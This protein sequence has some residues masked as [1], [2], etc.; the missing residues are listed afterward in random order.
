[1]SETRAGDHDGPPDR[2]AENAPERDAPRQDVPEEGI[3]G[4]PAPEKGAAR[5]TSGV[6]AVPETDVSQTTDAEPTV[7]EQGGLAR[8]R[9]LRR[10][11]VRRA[12]RW[13]VRTLIRTRWWW[14]LPILVLAAWLRWEGLDKPIW[15]DEVQ[16]ILTSE[17]FDLWGRP[18]NLLRPTIVAG[19]IAGWLTWT[20]ELTWVRL[21]YLLAGLISIWAAWRLGRLWGDWLT[22]VALALGLTLWPFK[23]YWDTM[24]RDYAIL[25][26]LAMGSLYCWERRRKDRKLVSAVAALLLTMM[27][28]LSHE[29]GWVLWSLPAYY[30][31]WEAALWVGR[32]TGNLCQWASGK[33]RERRR[34]KAEGNGESPERA[35]TEVPKSG[36]PRPSLFRQALGWMAVLA[37][38]AGFFTATV[39][40]NFGVE[41]SREFAGK[42]RTALI[43][44]DASDVGTGRGRSGRGTRGARAA[45]DNPY[46]FQREARAPNP[47]MGI[48][49][50]VKSLKAAYG[51]YT[52]HGSPAMLLGIQDMP[53]LRPDS[54]NNLYRMLLLG[55]VERN[56]DPFVVGWLNR[57]LLAGLALGSL[58]ALRRSPPLVLSL[59]TMIFLTSLIVRL[60]VHLRLPMPRYFSLAGLAGLVLLAIAAGGV[61]GWLR[62][63]L[64]KFRRTRALAT[65]AIGIAGAVWI[66]R[67][68]TREVARAA[69]FY[70]TDW[71]VL[72][73]AMR[74][75]YPEGVLFVGFGSKLVDFQKRLAAARFRREGSGDGWKNPAHDTVIEAYN[76]DFRREMQVLDRINPF[77]GAVFFRAREWP[78]SIN[79]LQDNHVRLRTLNYRDQWARGVHAE[80]ANKL[81]VTRGRVVLPLL[82]RFMPDRRPGT[83]GER[84]ARIECYF[85]TP[86]RYELWVI[87]GEGAQ[88]TGAKWQGRPAAIETVALEDAETDGVAEL[89]RDMR[90]LAGRWPAEPGHAPLVVTTATQGQR[91]TVTTGV[92]TLTPHTLELEFDRATVDP[93]PALIVRLG[94]Q[95]WNQVSPSFEAGDPV[96]WED[97]QAYYVGAPVRLLACPERELAARYWLTDDE[98]RKSFVSLSSELNQVNRGLQPGDIVWTGPLR[99]PKDLLRKQTGRQLALSI[100]PLQLDSRVSAGNVVEPAPPPGDPHRY[101]TLVHYLVCWMKPEVVDGQVRLAIGTVE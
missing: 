15:E 29:S 94:R 53:T 52:T 20:G 46:R 45:A 9:P 30:L 98:T 76:A 43:E 67:P 25:T 13:S 38:A 83:P 4:Q 73:A 57:L 33:W 92:A 41:K 88:L 14:V 6:Q 56:Y 84:R 49:F 7:P 8:A 55:P 26:M 101:G 35:A 36:L 60:N 51:D 82:H 70:S 78:E 18:Q 87:G 31:G 68:L 37:L 75:R 74:K 71:S 77:Q 19:Q 32:A 65:L 79:P 11:V 86:G 85:E 95:N 50:A 23:A 40:L 34:A 72:H 100:Q 28:A 64:W 22:A 39:V 5:Q 44:R 17:R 97:S 10:G 69:A 3:S 48:A 93:Q 89:A 81:F 61:A 59:W 2:P 27:G 90:F 80:T 16:G 96:V 42:A 66:T 12:G 54:R 58:L 63:P 1:M 99:I 47:R 91:L 24:V 21:P 62:L